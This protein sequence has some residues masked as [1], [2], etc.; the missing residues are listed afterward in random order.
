M[1][2]GKSDNGSRFACEAVC[3]ASTSKEHFGSAWLSQW[4]EEDHNRA[5]DVSSKSERSAEVETQQDGRALPVRCKNHWSLALALCLLWVRLADADAV[6]HG[7][8]LVK[9]K[10][11]VKEQKKV[12]E[13]GQSR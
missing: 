5:N 3:N 8:N 13:E 9:C 11:D 10:K 6:A 2:T 7:Q 12:Q 1:A 4:R